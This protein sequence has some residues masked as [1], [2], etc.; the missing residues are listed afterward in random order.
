MSDP[1]LPWPA[2]HGER[3]DKRQLALLV[4]PILLLVVASN[5]GNALG[6]RLQDSHPLLLVALSPLIRWQLLVINK[7]DWWAFFPIAAFRLLIPDPF[8][9]LLGRRYGDRAVKWAAD[10]YGITRRIPDLDQGLSTP[11]FRRILRPLVVIAPNNP[12]CLLAGAAAMP[13]AEF[14]TLNVIG[15]I[16]R[17][18]LIRL[19]ASWLSDQISTLAD[20]MTNNQKWFLIASVSIVV[21]TVSSQL[22]RS[23]GEIAGLIELAEELDEE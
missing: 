8:F 21:V 13:V 10:T 20:F 5:V 18:L 7:L 17:L 2:D 12:I 3:I 11:A 16:G 14:W 1:P 15:T 6:P 4:V 9:Y 23:K 19:A 22:F